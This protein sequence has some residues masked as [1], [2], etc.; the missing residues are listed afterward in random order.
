[1]TDSTMIHPNST[2]AE[3]TDSASRSELKNILVTLLQ[4]LG[5][6]AQATNLISDKAIASIDTAQLA[7]LL[8]KHHL[9]FSVY[10][11][12][13]TAL[14]QSIHPFIVVPES[15]PAF[16]ARR[17]GEVIE[18]LDSASN[19]WQQINYAELPK[20]SHIFVIESLPSSKQN[21]RAFAAH[22]SKRT[23]WYRPVF[24]L[25]LLSSITGLAVP[26]FTMAVYDKV[27]G[28]QAPN[29]LPSIALG[30]AL[31]LAILISSRLARANL[32]ATV[33]NRFARD[34][35]DITFRRL[36]SMPLMVL[37]RVGVSNHIA[38]MRNAEKVRT[39]LSGPGGAGL[40][41]LP[42]T[43]IAFVT[44]AL[45][46]GWLVLVPIVM[47]LL[48]YLVMKAVN[49][50]AQSASPT[51]SNDY[52]N[53]INELSKNLLQLK[54]SG[55]TEGWNTKFARQCKENCRQNFLYAKRNGLNAAVAHAMSLL[56]ALVT[57][58]TGI[59]LVLN[60]SISPGAL[61]ACVM[62]I[63]RITGPA[64]L[65]FSS[66]QKITMMDSAIKQFDRFMQAGTEHSEL[67]LDTPATDRAPAISF[68][69]V[70][71]RY[72]A[73][74]EPALAGVSVD[75]AAGE[76]VAIIGPNACGKTSML[77]AAMGVAEAQA[78]YIT[79]N[80]KNLK[81]YDPETFRLWAAFCPAEPDLFPGS[82]AENLRIAKPDASDEELIKALTAA[83]GS[84]L[85]A[86]LNNDLDIDLFNRG[87]TL[88]SAVEGSYISLARAL[89]KQSTLIIL[90]EPIAN[91]NPAAKAA[92]LNTFN[93]LKGQATVLFTSHDQE[94]IQQ[95]DKVVILDKGAV[96]YAGPIPDKNQ[97]QAAG[98]QEENSHG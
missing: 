6:Y 73:E 95:A 62:L 34:L 23:K 37:S 64:Q 92:L 35:S 7:G 90:D 61:I 79:V 15:E 11:L 32:L 51:I 48:F 57:V 82:L 67:R 83:G 85:F 60:Q 45:L 21:A 18:R 93:Q 20:S 66:S 70:T 49:K 88:L 98:S 13:K 1:M 24:W 58:F 63:W 44:I 27:I 97:S 94:L 28:G 19:Q 86:A 76:N 36:L 52:Q 47:L 84:S 2:I 22:M 38:R 59:F 55:D 29:V 65:A 74:T 78:G 9:D 43:L 8:K 3:A 33:S 53:S 54:T 17:H 40:V 68:Q 91:R 25:S 89:L 69:H 26:L 30:A 72:S 46:S 4:Q 87:H 41:D 5:L 80:D 16:L 71:L 14:S 96:V 12:H 39:L 77:L 56:T 81:Q 75:I 31:A 10:K 42:F 50:Y